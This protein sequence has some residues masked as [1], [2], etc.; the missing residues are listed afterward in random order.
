[1]SNKKILREAEEQI[2]GAL[3]RLYNNHGIKPFRIQVVND[4]EAE[5]IEVTIIKDERYS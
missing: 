3:Q 5:N 4:P 1:M 2:E